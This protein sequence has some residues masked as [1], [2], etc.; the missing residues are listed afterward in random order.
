[1]KKIIISVASL[2]LIVLVLFIYANSANA[3]QPEETSDLITITMTHASTNK[4]KNTYGYIMQE[5]P[6]DLADNLRI[7]A[8]N[9]DKVF[10]TDDIQDLQKG[11]YPVKV[12]KNGEKELVWLHID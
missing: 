8:K 5:D 1:M 10:L 12:E 3:E 11:E 4:L 7:R 9:F 2:F 6:Y